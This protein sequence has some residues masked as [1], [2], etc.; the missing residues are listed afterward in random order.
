DEL[1]VDGLPRQGVVAAVGVT[2]VDDRARQL[3]G[4]RGVEA[5]VDEPGAGDLDRGDAFG[6][7]EAGREG[8]RE[9]ARARAQTLGE[10]HR[11]V[12]RP[13]AVVAVLG[14]LDGDVLRARAELLAGSQLGRCGGEDVEDGG[15]ESFRTHSPRSYRRPPDVP[16]IRGPRAGAAGSVTSSSR[17]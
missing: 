2:R 9:L 17:S 8:G 5:D 1:E 12:R 4:R 6:R 3:A 10:L 15:G 16:R 13:V 14:P 11:R 7:L